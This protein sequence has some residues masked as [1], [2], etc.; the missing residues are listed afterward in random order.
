MSPTP[1]PPKKRD[2]ILAAIWGAFLAT[3][4]LLGIALVCVP[5]WGVAIVSLK[6]SN[7]CLR[8]GYWLRDKLENLGD[9]PE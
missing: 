7:T 6:V 9:K 4:W 3:C 1:T 8:T 5:L 2:S